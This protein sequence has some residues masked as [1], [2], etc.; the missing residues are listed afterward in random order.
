MIPFENRY[1]IL[2]SQLL[3][4]SRLGLVRHQLVLGLRL[5]A[6]IHLLQELGDLP[7]LK[8]DCSQNVRHHA[9]VHGALLHDLAHS[10]I[11]PLRATERRNPLRDTELQNALFDFLAGLS[12]PRNA[13]H[14]VL[15]RRAQRKVLLN[16]L[17]NLSSRVAAPGRHRRVRGNRVHLPNLHLPAPDITQ[18]W[19]RHVRYAC[20]CLYYNKKMRPLAAQRASLV[21]LTGT[22]SRGVGSRR[23]HPAR[24]A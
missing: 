22:S 7:G 4:S 5:A 20:V 13:F 23:A 19:F 18:L 1:K 16:V 11:A 3:L 17:F 8:K 15:D 21:P 2:T 6:S 14:S 9:F 24:P 10:Q 12:R